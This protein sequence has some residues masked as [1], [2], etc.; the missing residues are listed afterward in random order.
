MEN[1][2]I[3][4]IDD[5]EIEQVDGATSSLAYDAGHYVGTKMRESFNS[6]YYGAMNSAFQRAYSR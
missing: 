4:E 3:I 1:D 2:Q 6:F 5:F